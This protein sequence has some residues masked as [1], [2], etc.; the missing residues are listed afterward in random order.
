MEPV[1]GNESA[2]KIWVEQPRMVGVQSKH[3]ENIFLG[4]YARP[5]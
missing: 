4:L 2:E 3:G 1:E 5:D